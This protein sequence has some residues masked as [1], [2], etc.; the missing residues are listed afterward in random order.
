MSMATSIYDR[1]HWPLEVLMTWCRLQAG[2]PREMA[3]KFQEQIVPEIAGHASIGPKHLEV[4]GR[5]CFIE[6]PDRITP[7]A[8]RE[9][10]PAY[11]FIDG[12][13]G[14]FQGQYLLTPPAVLFY[15][16]GLEK[17]PQPL[18]DR[19]VERTTKTQRVIDPKNGRLEAWRDL[20]LKAD[21]ARAIWGKK[22]KVS[23]ANDLKAFIADSYPDG[24][25]GITYQEV[26][27]AHAVATKRHKPVD[28]RTVARALGKA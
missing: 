22:R 7:G 16:K 17:I 21:Q 12:C 18:R 28:P 6:Y 13:L 14:I 8:A 23:S 26:A 25:V 20:W 19:M 15:E 1:P 2:V 11:E 3:E 27:N 5:P 24:L 10:I 9:C 4:S